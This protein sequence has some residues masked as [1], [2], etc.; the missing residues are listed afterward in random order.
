MGVNDLDD[1]ASMLGDES[2]AVIELRSLFDLCASY[3]IEE[4]IQLDVSVV[5][6]LSYYTGTVFEAHDRE[7]ELRPYAEAVAMTS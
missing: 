4:W 5:R 2:P 1:L 3:G 7:G 6:G